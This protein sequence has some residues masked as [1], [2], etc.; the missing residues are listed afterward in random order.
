MIPLLAGHKVAGAA[1]G[2]VN[3]F[4]Q[5]GSVTVPT[6]IGLVY[7]ATSGSF[8]AAFATLAAG[9]IIGAVIA[10]FIREPRREQNNHLESTAAEA[11]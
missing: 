4:W 3:A 11:A 7:A 10:F 5:L 2:A 8:V 1:A 6:V 9:P